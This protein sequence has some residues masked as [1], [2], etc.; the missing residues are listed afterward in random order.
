MSIVY[1]G[2]LPVGVHLI[3]VH[4]KLY[5]ERC[6]RANVSKTAQPTVQPAQI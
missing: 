5:K 4:L 1:V 3:L 6:D 2:H